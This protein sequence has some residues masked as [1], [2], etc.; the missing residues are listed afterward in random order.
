MNEWKTMKLSQ[1]IV[2]FLLIIG[3]IITGSTEHITIPLMSSFYE[4]I[5]FILVISTLEG[6]FNY[7]LILIIINKKIPPMKNKSTLVLAGLFSTLMSFFLIYS[8][9]PTRTPVLIQSIFLGL[10]LIPSIILTK[11]V[12]KKLIYYNYKYTIPSLILLILSV[13]IATTPLYH[14]LTD[15]TLWVIGYALGVFFLSLTNI[16]QEKYILDTQDHTFINKIGLAFYTSV[17]QFGF[18]I[19]FCWVEILF[20]YNPNPIQSFINSGYTF[21]TNWVHFILLQLF[22]FDCL[23]L[24]VLSIY[25]NAISTNY[26]MILTNLTNQSVAIFFEIFPS[27]NHGLKYSPYIVASSLIL[28]IIS[29]VLWIKGEVKVES[30]DS[31]DTDDIEEKDNSNQYGTFT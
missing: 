13:I 7:G 2:I 10:A 11:Y 16:Y 9:N 12:L 14:H 26:N 3:I 5:Y 18:I 28:N 4:S 31:D 21:A 19:L 1:N 15:T 17:F 6:I 30:I 22:I 29:V 27:L 24:Y 20:G 23:G 8:A 25:L